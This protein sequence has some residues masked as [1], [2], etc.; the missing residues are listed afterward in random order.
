ME[1]YFHYRFEDYYKRV[2]CPLLMLPDEDVVDSWRGHKKVALGVD[3]T[4]PKAQLLYENV[5]M[6]CVRRFDEYHKAV[7]NDVA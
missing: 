5:G 7:E 1:H 4:R 3:S 6:V 2:A